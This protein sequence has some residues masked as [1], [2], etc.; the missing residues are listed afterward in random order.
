MNNTATAVISKSISKDDLLIE[1][2]DLLTIYEVT[3]IR[4]NTSPERHRQAVLGVE[5]LGTAYDIV[6]SYTANSVQLTRDISYHKYSF[7]YAKTV[8]ISMLTD[9][10]NSVTLT[11]L[12]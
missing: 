12:T 7:Q 9:Y 5:M 1:L 8:N 10:I 11:M 2:E 4:P 3:A 6:L